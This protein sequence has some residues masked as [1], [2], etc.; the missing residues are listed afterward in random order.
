MSQLKCKLIN[1]VYLIIII[2]FSYA[3]IKTY[4]HKKNYEYIKVINE[5]NKEIKDLKHKIK[6]LKLK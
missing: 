6:E 5:Q 4:T 2:V 1:I 3:M